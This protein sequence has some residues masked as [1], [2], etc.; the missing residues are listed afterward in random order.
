MS[1]FNLSV[2]DILIPILFLGPI[3]VVTGLAAAWKRRSFLFWCAAGV[4]TG[5][6]ALLAVIVLP[7]GRPREDA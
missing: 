2:Q 3:G 7:A 4:L 1:E 5:G 6:F